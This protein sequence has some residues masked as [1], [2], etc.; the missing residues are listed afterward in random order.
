MTLPPIDTQTTQGR[1]NLKRLALYFAGSLAIIAL[2]GAIILD[3]YGN[4]AQPAWTF[5]AFAAGVVGG[6]LVPNDD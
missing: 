1:Q 2:I 6:V 5:L 3:I 4:D